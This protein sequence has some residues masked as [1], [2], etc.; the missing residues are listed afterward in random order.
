TSTETYR[1]LRRQLARTVYNT[2]NHGMAAA[3]DAAMPAAA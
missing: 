1:C 2:L 3:P